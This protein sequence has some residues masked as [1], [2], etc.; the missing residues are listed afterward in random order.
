MM[1]LSLKG[2]LF[3]I[4]LFCLSILR[5][6]N[7]VAQPRSGF[8]YGEGNL[9]SV[10]T[11][12]KKEDSSIPQIL[13]QSRKIFDVDFVYESN[14]LPDVKLYMDVSKYKGV[15]DFL[16]E[17]LKPYGLRYKKVLTRTY[18]IYKN[19]DELKKMVAAMRLQNPGDII[20][21]FAFNEVEVAAPVRTLTGLIFDQKTG[22]PVEGVNIVIKGTKLGTTSDR[23]GSFKINVAND[24]D[25]LVFTIIGYAPQEIVV[26]SNTNIQVQMTATSGTLNDV[27][28]VGYGT[29]KR[30]E[31]TTAISSLN[32]KEI[33]VTPVADAAQ[34][35][36]GKVS[37]VTIVQGSG[38][39]GGTGGTQIRIRG[40]TSLTGTNNPLIVVDG[41][42]LP[43]QGA[44]NVLNSFGTN[45]IE[46][47]DVLKDAAASSIYGVRASNGVIMIT[48]KRGK[49]GQSKMSVDVYRGLQQ[50]WQLP[51]MLNAREYAILNSE[52]RIASGLDVIPKLANPDAI[53]QQ[54][55]EGTKWLDEIFR[56]AAIQSVS[57][58]A[59]GGSDKATYMLSAGY[60]KQDGIVY[61]T[62]FERFNLRFNGDVKVNNKIKLGNTLSLSK[63]IEHGADT[64]SAFN[65]V[66][67]LALTSPPTVTPRN[68]D[69]TYAGGN[70]NI[71]GFSEPNPVYNLEVP[72]TSNTKYRVTG[73]VFA[74]WEIIKAL[75][76]KTTFGA[77]YAYNDVKSFSPATPSSGGQ[78]ITIDG[79]GQT[80]VTI[81]DYLAE[82]T[83]T[84][85]KTIKTKHRF[86]A[87]AGYTFQETQYSI[88]SGGRSGIFNYQIPVLNNAVFLPQ[89]V[90][91]ISNYSQDDVTS[92][93]IS[94]IGRL[95]YTYDNKVYFTGSLRRDGSS[96][97][98]PANKFAFFPSFSLAWRISEE[99]FVKE[100]DWI[101][102]LKIRSSFGYTGNP[103]V[104]PYSYL[105]RIDQ[106]F[107]YPLGNSSGTE[108]ANQGAAPTAPSNPDIKWEKNEQ[109]DI[110]IDASLFKSKLTIALDFYQKRSK[111]LIL[112]VV[113]IN[114][115]GNYVSVPYNTGILQNRG[116]DLT[117]SGTILSS[118]KLNWNANLVMSTF[119]NEVIS[120]GL[121]TSFDKGFARISG[122]SLRT[123]IGMPAD[124]FYGFQTDGIFQTQEEIA[125][126][127]VQTPGTDPTN[128][129]APGDIKFKDINNDGII[130]EKDRT[131][132]GNSFPKFT[133]GLNNT[134]TYKGFELRVF[135]QGSQGN[136]VLNF[137]RWYTEGGVSN[138]N[139]SKDVINRWTGPGTSNSMPRLIL[140]DP[141]GNNRVSDRFVENASYLRIKNVRLAYSLPDKWAKVAGLGKIQ[142][143]GSIQ[144]LLTFTQYSGLDP[145]VGGGVDY[146]FY[147]QARTFLGGI[148][149]D[150]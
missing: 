87:L 82:Y 141:N 111:D 95:N 22:L 70:G 64:Y 13:S 43:D 4:V 122:G 12:E 67:I 48:T 14:I 94:Y 25:V 29:R 2:K 105:T 130:N 74:E 19:N 24:S 45:D 3:L 92:R 116:I 115:S 52:A 127:A 137:T 36:Q 71:D 6:A 79:Y 91:Q 66:I 123:D 63:F 65:S 145:E 134:I 46:S 98:A 83:L 133:F 76:F 148:T 90:S 106:G 8:Q 118:K 59:S 58:T 147:P 136:K 28:V 88:L 77:D 72:K 15:E 93:F 132:L 97:F 38:A 1:R 140:N 149:V 21:D 108:G 146:G 104:I 17:L 26:G 113:P 150:F 44:D 7:A 89:N 110:G 37:G 33:A 85:D 42:P 126:S 101:T 120:F 119:K 57:L 68:A 32:A 62:D 112:Y 34:A 144:N 125:K 18:V 11:Y 54:Y 99:S 124:F 31:L 27:V 9:Q 47:I 53:E 35:L 61:N 56:K 96:N 23:T 131:N 30:K 80:K 84:Y 121:G 142:L 39:P 69:G 103:N 114:V 16:D 40:I 60:L 51:E 117:V 81:P 100:I 5:P 139:Y 107:Q 50:A 10:E 109:L 138:G 75:K 49:A 143:Y 102:D 128:S 135:I 86:N 129:T 73:N 55:G 41:Y 78:P 20:P